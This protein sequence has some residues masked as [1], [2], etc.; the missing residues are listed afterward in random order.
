MCTRTLTLDFKNPCS[1][2]NAIKTI[3]FCF[4]PKQGNLNKGIDQGLEI[5]AQKLKKL[6][7]AEKL[8]QPNGSH[9][10]LCLML[11]C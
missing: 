4:K 6:L 7:T 9:C 11:K 10:L 8:I 1:T 3:S 2:G 5:F